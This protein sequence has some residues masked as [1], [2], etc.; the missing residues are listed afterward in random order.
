MLGLAGRDSLPDPLAV[1]FKSHVKFDC[2]TVIASE[3][4]IEVL[5]DLLMDPV[6]Q[7][8]LA[9]AQALQ[10]LADP[11]VKGG[12]EMIVKVLTDEHDDGFQKIAHVFH[13]MDHSRIP[14]T[15][16]AIG[17]VAT[18]ILV[19]TPPKDKKEKGLSLKL[20]KKLL[21]SMVKPY[22]E[23]LVME[24]RAMGL[25]KQLLV[26]I[27]K[28]INIEQLVEEDVKAIDTFFLFLAS[29]SNITILRT[30]H[31]LTKLVT[32]SLLSLRTQWSEEM[33]QQH[34]FQQLMQNVI[35]STDKNIAQAY[36]S[37]LNHVLRQCDQKKLMITVTTLKEESLNAAEKLFIAKILYGCLSSVKTDVMS[38]TPVRFPS[39]RKA[40]EKSRLGLGPVNKLEIA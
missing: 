2:R 25:V 30:L 10:N 35:R 9:A 40:K 13:V 26:C 11:A 23:K 28:R 1:P 38:S 24:G 6:E 7:Q 18:S 17:G 33:C 5:V 34:H 27:T 15:F 36:R 3:E 12:M 4:G 20:R 31:L 16:D 37:L 19:W 32:T 14:E 21:H 8:Q 22:P 39:L 29:E